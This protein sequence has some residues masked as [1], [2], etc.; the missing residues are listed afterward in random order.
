MVN[1]TE[2]NP[3]LT[4]SGNCREAMTFYRDCLGGKLEMLEVAESP[5]ADQWPAEAQKLILHARLSKKNLTLL[6][7]DIGGR[8]GLCKGNSVSLALA[9]GN[10]KELKRYFEQL[11]RGGRITHEL[12]DFY[13]G[14]IGAVIDKYGNNWILKY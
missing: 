5:M 13:D 4:F 9:C 8:D 10:E 11:S 14:T 12:H 6:A 1:K 7:S 2:I 3:Y